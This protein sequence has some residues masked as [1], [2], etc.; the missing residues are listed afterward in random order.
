[1]QA[2]ENL[3]IFPSKVAVLTAVIVELVCLLNPE[4]VLFMLIQHRE[5]GA[6]RRRRKTK[7]IS[8]KHRS[9]FINCLSYI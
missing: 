8:I 9:S 4:L 3:I 2:V 5:K 6:T 1:M 7:L